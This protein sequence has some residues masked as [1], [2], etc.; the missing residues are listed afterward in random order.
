M[1]GL[2]GQFVVLW[3]A[4]WLLGIVSAGTAVLIGSAVGNIKTA[5]EGAPAV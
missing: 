3:F 4:Y 1:I 2:N 5:M